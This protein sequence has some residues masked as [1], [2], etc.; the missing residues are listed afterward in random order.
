METQ[1]AITCSRRSDIDSEEIIRQLTNG[2]LL[3]EDDG[4]VLPSTTRCADGPVPVSEVK[5]NY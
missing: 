3:P 2:E 1:A 4:R 5:C